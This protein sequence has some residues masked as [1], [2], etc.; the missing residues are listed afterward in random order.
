MM[1]GE[2]DAPDVEPSVTPQRLNLN[3]VTGETGAAALPLQ[4]ALACERFRFEAEIARYGFPGPRPALVC[5]MSDY[6]GR[7]ALALEPPPGEASPSE[8]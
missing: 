2:I 3:S 1:L 6:P 5:E 8:G 4:L 7:G